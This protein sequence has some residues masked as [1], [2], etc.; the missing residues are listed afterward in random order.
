MMAIS[1]P[2]IILLGGMGFVL[3]LGAA[4]VGARTIIENELPGGLPSQVTRQL[5]HTRC[6]SFHAGL[7]AMLPIVSNHCPSALHQTIRAPLR[8]LEL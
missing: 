7:L 1:R 6:H 4:N 5:V 8:A 2:P 3:A